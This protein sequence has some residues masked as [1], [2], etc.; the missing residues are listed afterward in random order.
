MKRIF[1][2]IP[3]A[4]L[5]YLLE[6]LSDWMFDYHFK[7]NQFTSKLEEWIDNNL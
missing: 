5:I 2:V 1:V 6:G 7:I 4:L 3:V